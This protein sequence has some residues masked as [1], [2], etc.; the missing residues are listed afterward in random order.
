MIYSRRLTQLVQ[1]KRFVPYRL[2]APYCHEV[3][4]IY[5]CGYWQKYYTVIEVDSRQVK[6]CWED[7]TETIHS[8]SL[9]P[10][11]DY[12]LKEMEFVDV[13]VPENISMTFA[14]IKSHLVIGEQFSPKVLLDFEN[15]Y[16]LCKAR[17]P[18]DVTY[19]YLCFD[20]NRQKL[21]L[22]RDLIKS[23]R[24]AEMGRMR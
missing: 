6:A 24:A 3:G 8:T 1:E 16:L 23:P 19:Y 12:Q 20:K 5:W 4:A 13:A 22:S 14:E 9:N 21:F 18:N 11:L 7:G 10:T 15:R 2:V 17:C